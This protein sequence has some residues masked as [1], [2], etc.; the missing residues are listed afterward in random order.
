MRRWQ[1]RERC[2]EL[3][4][5]LATG[6]LRDINDLITYNLNIR[7]FA[8]D[9]IEN[10]EGPELLRAFWRALE[11][12]TIL[13]PTCGSGAFL[14]AALNILEPLYDACLIRMQA[15]VEDLKRSG[16]KH[17]PEKF[18]DFRRV[19]ERVAQHPNHRYFMLKS[20]IVN[21]LFGVDI[22]EEATEICKLRLFLKLVAQIERIEDIEPL[23]DVDFNVRAGNTLVGNATR[24]DV[25][26]VVAASLFATPGMRESQM[27]IYE[28]AEGVD[29][30]FALF[31][32]QQTEFD[33]L[34]T[35][36]DKRRLQ[37]RL[38]NLADQLNHYLAGTHGVEV[39]DTAQYALWCRSHKPFHWFIEF[40][41]ITE[42]GG[43]DAIIASVAVAPMAIQAITE[44]T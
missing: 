28:Q 33:G 11:K 21:N 1:R 35:S 23:P 39:K 40:H 36:V 20:I 2:L 29:R 31:R 30:L 10:C 6:N 25:D 32:E 7:Q 12:M 14:F 9:V 15:F 43:F 34:V 38:N 42:R 37:D 41:S 18:N 17:R 24:D 5:K 22:M 16:Q 44:P 4:E 3:R 8:Q 13:D 19:L 27:R 26:K